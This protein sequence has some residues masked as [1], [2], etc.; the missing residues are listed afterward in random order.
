METIERER[1][2]RGVETRRENESVRV[3]QTWTG[4]IIEPVS[5]GPTRETREVSVFT[6]VELN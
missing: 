3:R 6:R 1:A 2:E 4:F 5:S